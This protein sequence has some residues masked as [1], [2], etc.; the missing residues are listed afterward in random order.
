MEPSLCRNMPQRVYSTAF[1]HSVLLNNPENAPGHFT[2]ILG[3]LLSV[4]VKARYPSLGFQP[5]EEAGYG[6]SPKQQ[7]RI[8][9]LSPR[10]FHQHQTVLRQNYGEHISF[11]DD[12]IEIMYRI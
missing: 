8:T 3:T 9:R 7:K 12:D 6:L 10:R 2:N 1:A 5:D 11:H 4:Q